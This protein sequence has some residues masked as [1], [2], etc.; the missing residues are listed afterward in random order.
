MATQVVS[1]I[2]EL[3]EIEVPLAE[4]FDHPTVSAMAE[5]V[6]SIRWAVESHE[7]SLGNESDDRQEGE[8]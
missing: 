8:L 7:T 2:R 5:C 4:F 3:L 6:D 1:R